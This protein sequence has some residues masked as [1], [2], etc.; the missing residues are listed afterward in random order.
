MKDK[1]IFV[2]I[3]VFLLTACGKKNGNFE[4]TGK[5]HGLVG[6]RLKLDLLGKD[7]KIG[8]DS[9]T[10]DNEGGFRFKG[11]IENPGFYV[12]S[13]GQ[14]QKKSK[15][16]EITLAVY[17]GDKIFIFINGKKPS[18]YYGIQGSTDSRRIQTL[19]SSIEYSY[20]KIKSL[21]KIFFNN[22]RNQN[23]VKIKERLDSLNKQIFEQQHAFTQKFISEKPASLS[24]LMALY[25]Q[26]GP[27]MSVMELPKD[28]TLFRS[29]SSSLYGLWPDSEPVKSLFNMVERWEDQQ[30]S[31][32]YSQKR[33]EI[34]KEA[35]EIVL[36]DTAGNAI[37]LSSLRGKY[38]VLN[39]WASW[40]APSRATNIMLY[41]CFWRYLK[42]RS[43]KKR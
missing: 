19:N 24:S 9:V 13:F 8:I 17:P 4:L 25:Q 30:K 15:N 36:P 38:V 3:V 35:P 16:E 7:A 2:L 11:K 20:I 43:T 34:G 23:I 27:H 10:L 39:F 21:G 26:L 28:S 33:L 37:A 6:Q 5:V 1:F 14:S 12:L 29:V 41:R 18:K 32:V 22:I 40:D 31:Q 42:F